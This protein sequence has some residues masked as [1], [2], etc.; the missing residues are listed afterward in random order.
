MRAIE[1]GLG[2]LRRVPTLIAWGAA[3]PLF[4][5]DIA[6][7]WKTLLPRA[8]GPVFIDSAGHFVAE[9]AP[10]ELVRHLDGFLERS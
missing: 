3:D 5:P 2:A 8:T 9:D 1:T 6:Q 7:H 10:D 4:L